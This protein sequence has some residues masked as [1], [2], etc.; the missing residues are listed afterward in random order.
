[1]RVGKAA[2]LSGVA[3]TAALLSPAEAIEGRETPPSAVAIRQASA[4]L[5]AGQPGAVWREP[6]TGIELVWIPAGRFRMGSDEEM[7]DE[8][9]SHS[10][11]LRG[12]WM[13][14]TEVTQGQ[15]KAVLGQVPARF[16]RSAHHPVETVD[17]EDVQGFIRALSARS[18]IGFRL[19]TE[20]E[21][22]YACRAGREGPDWGPLFDIAWFDQNSRG[23]THP[24][25]R[26]KPNAWGL[27]DTQGNVWEW[28]QDW[29]GR[30]DGRPQVDPAGPASGAARVIRGGCW[31]VPFYFLRP[32]SR[33]SALPSDR[34]D[35]LGLRLAVS[36]EAG[37]RTAAGGNH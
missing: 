12:F 14:R 18:G 35:Y 6:V 2:L 25:G 28:C 16:S 7:D 15:W 3:L 10:V 24:V 20:A 37:P 32:V 13:G 26:K 1:M 5:P 30:Y 33:G 4:S 8:G 11:R 22:E 27:Y 36:G 21:W 29:Y 34:G 23:S 19:P 31:S 9:P 17:W